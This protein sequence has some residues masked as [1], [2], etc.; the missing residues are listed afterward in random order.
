MHTCKPYTEEQLFAAIDMWV[1]HNNEKR[2]IQI[3][4]FSF[5]EKLSKNDPAIYREM[6][7]VFFKQN[8]D[9]IKSISDAKNNQDVSTIDFL[10][11]QYKSCVRI[12]N[13]KKQLTI[14]S[15]LEERIKNGIAIQ[16]LSADI[17]KLIAT[18]HTI[19]KEIENKLDSL[20][21]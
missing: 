14:I 10:L 17:D 5:L 9:L 16:D 19:E 6:L 1:F 15:V 8:N 2:S 21:V 18:G 3:T 11:H 4:D 13:I 7:E 12:L 20:N